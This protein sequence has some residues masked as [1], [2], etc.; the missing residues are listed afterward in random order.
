MSTDMFPD[1]FHAYMA[2]HGL[3]DA[4]PQSGKPRVIL[5]NGPPESGKD[6]AAEMLKD[7]LGWPAWVEKFA[8][9]VK[10]G[11][12]GL[13]GIVDEVGRVLRHDAF[14][15][16]K[17]EPNYEFMGMSPRQAYIWYSEEVMKPKFGQAIFGNMAVINMLKKLNEFRES[18]RRG[19]VV[20]S[21]PYF[22]ISD[23]GF[24]SET[25]P[26]VTAFGA[27]NVL[28]IRLYRDG[29]T[30]ASD[31]RSYI[32]PPMVRKVDVVNCGTGDFKKKLSDVVAAWEAGK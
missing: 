19:V 16:V 3:P 12:H 23:S 28:L 10:E 8:R 30:F 31:S 14:E 20:D 6:T 13:F 15:K 1:S 11:C 26:V 4:P 29:K 22:L 25:D 7:E 21:T 2:K 9:P 5:L 17:N 32:E 27:C 18:V 24:Q